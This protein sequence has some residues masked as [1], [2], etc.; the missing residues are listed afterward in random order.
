MATVIVRASG[1]S[2]AKWAHEEQS[3]IA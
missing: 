2:Q 3:T 1:M